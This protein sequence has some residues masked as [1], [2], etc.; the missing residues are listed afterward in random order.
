ME[1]FTS[2]IDLPYSK[3]ADELIAKAMLIQKF[4][5]AGK[6]KKL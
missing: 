2:I 6:S 3:I 4:S 1:D 5:Q